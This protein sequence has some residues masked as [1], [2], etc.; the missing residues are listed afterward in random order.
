MR[1]LCLPAIESCACISSVELVRRFI[2][3]I[4]KVFS[5]HHLQVKFVTLQELHANHTQSLKMS[6]KFELTCTVAPDYWHDA[7]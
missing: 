3:E 2:M 1:K 7:Q 5:F 6:V 4:H